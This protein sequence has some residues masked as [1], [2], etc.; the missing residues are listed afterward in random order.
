[1]VEISAWVWGFGSGLTVGLGLW[2]WSSLSWQRQLSRLIRMF[3]S[4]SYSATMSL[5]VRLRKAVQS[6]QQSALSLQQRL[7]IWQTILQSAPIGY[8]E[9]DGENHVY[10]H[11]AKA[12]V[13]LNIEPLHDRSTLGRS[14]LQV[15]R[16]YELD[17]LIESIRH[18]QTPQCQ[19]W[20]FHALQ[21]PQQAK[22]FPLRG[23]GF[24]LEEGHIGVFIEDRW[25]AVQLA[26]E[27]DRWTSDVAHELKTPLTSIR[28]IAETLQPSIDPSLRGW[29]DRLI[30]ET[31]RL[32]IL[33]QDILELS[34]I[35]FQNPNALKLT[36]TDVPKLIQNAWM[37]L[38]PLAQHKNLSLYYEGL[39]H[40][41]LP[42][43]GNRLLRVFM[44]LIDNGIKFSPVD[45]AIAI[46]LRPHVSCSLS[47]GTEATDCTQIEVVDAGSGFPE[48]SLNHVFKRFYKADPA[49]GRTITDLSGHIPT[50]GGSGLGLAIAH[51]I[52][53][54]HGGTISAKNHG[55]HGGAC[56]QILLPNTRVKISSSV[57][58][59][60]P[61]RLEQG[62]LP[63]QT[64]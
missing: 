47:P 41:L 49:R 56:L 35:T 62:I 15:V 59:S 60:V 17:Q 6:Q 42:A 38:E 52:I 40:H 36:E 48:E 30:Q 19:E 11:N 13:L 32:S 2:Y 12:V 23:S 16:S 10:W 51:Q 26:Q 50:G 57:Q 37:T 18:H 46:H 64:L 28:L 3:P 63:P 29:V 58:Q 22:D 53:T 45:G 54:A 25:E 27:R 33:V 21:N 20:T 31:V 24:P 4:Q 5:Q 44:N 8:L 61:D 9:V 7:D 39:D 34:Q 14:L 1:V 43:D 55:T